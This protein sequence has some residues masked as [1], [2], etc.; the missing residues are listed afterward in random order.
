MLD[1]LFEVSLLHMIKVSQNAVEHQIQSA[2]AWKLPFKAG[3]K[4]QSAVPP[5]SDAQW[6]GKTP[7]IVETQLQMDCSKG[8]QVIRTN[9]TRRLF[10]LAVLVRG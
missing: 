10:V 7:V 9:V 6:P 5:S 4:A 3:K 1:R 2:V 8:H